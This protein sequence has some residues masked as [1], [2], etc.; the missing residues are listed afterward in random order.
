MYEISIK[1]QVTKF[2]RKQPLWVSQKFEKAL[3]MLKENPYRRDLDIK[4][5]RGFENDYRLRIGNYRFLY[6]IIQNRL[7]IYMY[8][9]GSRGDVY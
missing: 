3:I 4:K 1:K 7:L 9:A 2:L 6:K 8:K 5:L